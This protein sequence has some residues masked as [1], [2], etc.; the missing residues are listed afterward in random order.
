MAVIAI[1]PMLA[2]Q[3]A[4]VRERAE[5]A[6]DAEHAVAASDPLPGWTGAAG[7]RPPRGSAHSTAWMRS[8]RLFS[9]GVAAYFS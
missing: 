6:R 3:S 5:K 8:T 4:G 2:I 9:S 7:G 1:M